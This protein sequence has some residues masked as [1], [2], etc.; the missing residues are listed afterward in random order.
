L[1]DEKSLKGAVPSPALPDEKEKLR[2]K[3]RVGNFIA[4]VLEKELSV[5][6]FDN[7]Q[8]MDEAS[9]ELIDYLAG[10]KKIPLCIFCPTG[11]SP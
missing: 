3:V 10:S 8:W 2:L 4:N 1:P 7:A 6:I 5:L 11:K 9:L